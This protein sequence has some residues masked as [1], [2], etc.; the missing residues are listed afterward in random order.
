MS[1]TKSDGMKNAIP[2]SACHETDVSQDGKMYEF[3]H[4]NAC[5]WM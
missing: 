4:I 5:A 2:L 3:G 1:R